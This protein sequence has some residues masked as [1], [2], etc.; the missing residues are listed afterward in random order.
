[1]HVVFF[2]T[3]TEILL[4]Q[5]HYYYFFFLVI[6]KYSSQYI[7]QC[8]QSFMAPKEN[9]HTLT[10]RESEVHCPKS[11]GESRRKKIFIH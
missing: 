7:W 11:H 2:S 10:D 9:E 3:D 6:Y 1:M 8:E 4:L 5:I